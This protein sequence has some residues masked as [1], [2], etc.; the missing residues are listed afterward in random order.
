MA[1]FV[2]LFGYVLLFADPEFMKA[3]TLL[4]I[5]QVRQSNNSSLAQTAVNFFVLID[6]LMVSFTYRKR[7]I[8]DML[9]HSYCVKENMSTQVRTFGEEIATYCE[10][11]N[12]EI[13]HDVN[14]CPHCGAIFHE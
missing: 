12:K 1:L 2:G 7:A 3:T 5:I 6:G 11:C 10:Q 14:V 4:D 13:P 8:H 9:A